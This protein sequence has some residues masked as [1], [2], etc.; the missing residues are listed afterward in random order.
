MFVSIDF[1]IRHSLIR[2][3]PKWILDWRINAYYCWIF[4]K[5]PR[6]TIVG[7]KFNLV[8]P[9]LIELY[10]IHCNKLPQF[11]INKL[12]IDII[13]NSSS[14]YLYVSEELKK[15]GVLFTSLSKAV[16]L[17]PAYIRRYMGSVVSHNDNYFAS[18]NA[19]VYTDGTFV[20]LPNRIKCPLILS[21][22]FRINKSCSGQFER[23]LIILE[24]QSQACYFEGCNSN[25][26]NSVL[27]AA[28]VEIILKQKSSLKYSTFQ[29]WSNNSEN[30]IIN[31]VTKRALCLG[32]NSK[33]IWIQVEIGSIYTWK[34]PSSIL[35]SPYAHSEFYSLGISNYE[36][37]IETGTKV[38]H[39]S[40][41]CNSIVVSKSVVSGKSLN[42]FRSLLDIRSDLCKNH[43]RC[44]TFLLS[45]LCKT[46]TFPIIKINS[47][48]SFL[49]Y[50]SINNYITS[51]QLCYCRQRGLTLMDILKIIISEHANEI[52]KHLPL[53][54]SLEVI[55]LLFK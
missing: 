41:N 22:Y 15:L 32:Y 42:I 51:L 25:N 2:R 16:F 26:I 6:W 33:I 9:N 18:L 45:D 4:K 46:Y 11:K 19:C 36:Q 12:D 44:N 21:T 49:E 40:K 29:N 3:E 13:Y 55:K 53:D 7:A 38:Y 43:T 50:E 20:I 27:H 31:F 47:K 35:V 54:I 5:F 10:N 28:V 34:Y 8:K 14:V 30:G 39:L 52:I 24:N 17:Y 48:F 23:T 1:I 37:C